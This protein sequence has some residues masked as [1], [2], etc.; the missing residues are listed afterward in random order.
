VTPD[1][2]IVASMTVTVHKDFDVRVAKAEVTTGLH[3][4][5]HPNRGPWFG[6]ATGMVL[7]E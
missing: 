4:T 6:R 5:A 1:G 2:V 7:Q 3:W